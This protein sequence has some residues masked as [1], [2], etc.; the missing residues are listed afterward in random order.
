VIADGSWS[1]DERGDVLV[2]VPD[3]TE[4]PMSLRKPG[5]YE[6]V[7]CATKTYVLS[8]TEAL[9]EELRGSGMRVSCLAPGPAE[10]RF[11]ARADM[12]NTRL[13]R[14]GAMDARRVAEAG[15]DGVRRGKP[16]VLP[17]LRNRLMAASV[18]LAPRGLTRRISARLQA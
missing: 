11:A 2:A 5:P 16:L 3:L 8:F 6:A 13:F 14:R 9:A 17:G 10:T 18:H 4:Q 15:Y 12:L 7:Y 1:D